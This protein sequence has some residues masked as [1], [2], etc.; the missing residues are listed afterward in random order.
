MMLLIIVV[1]VVVVVVVVVVVA[2]AEKVFDIIGIRITIRRTPNT[3]LLI[4][5]GV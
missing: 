5:C 3:F 1:L 2:V 4:Y